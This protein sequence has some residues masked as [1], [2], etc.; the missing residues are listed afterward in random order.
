M[1]IIMSMRQKCKQGFELLEPN[2]CIIVLQP[3]DNS[4]TFCLFIV[5]VCLASQ[6]IRST[7]KLI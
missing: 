5:T 7:A 4:Q 3:L 6:V 2:Q 1:M